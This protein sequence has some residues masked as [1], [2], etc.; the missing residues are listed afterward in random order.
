MSISPSI[1]LFPLFSHSRSLVSHP[2]CNSPSHTLLPE[3]HSIQLIHTI[4]TTDCYLA[5]D[6]TQRQ[7]PRRIMLSSLSIKS[8][9][10][11]RV[12]SLQMSNAQRTMNSSITANIEFVDSFHWSSPLY[13][14]DLCH[15]HWY[16]GRRRISCHHI[17][18]LTVLWIKAISPIPVFGLDP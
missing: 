14:V 17:S 1:S 4:Y 16:G 10:F 12:L 3:P 18:L 8:C 13:W 2:T 5:K 9:Y 6:D 11:T 7:F 15:M